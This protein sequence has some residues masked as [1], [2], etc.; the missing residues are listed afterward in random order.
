MNASNA[1]DNGAHASSLNDL[2]AVWPRRVQAALAAVL[3]ATVSIITVH[4]I[5]GGLRDARPTSVERNAF[6]TARVDL[7]SADE[8]E[9]RQLPDV[10]EQLAGRIVKHRQLNGPFRNVEELQ[11]V[12]GIGK[13]KL[14]RLSPWLYVEHDAEDEE[15]STKQT[16]MS[17]K[18]ASG[19][20]PTR[21][22]KGEGLTGPIDLNEAS[23]EELQRLPGIVRVVADTIVRASKVKPFQSVDELD[24]VPGIG[25]K[26]LEKV[27]PFVTVTRKRSA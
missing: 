11:R 27:R 2:L 9:L 18:K 17:E 20:A 6:P 4:V 13:T 16:S 21:V 22:R 15:G 8:A 24:K 25:P 26:T 23:A 12:P 10:G 19:A 5:A 1:T 7:N 14:D 3:L